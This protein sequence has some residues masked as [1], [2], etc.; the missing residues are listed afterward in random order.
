MKT[1]TGRAIE[2]LE[3][4]G[5]T[6]GIVERRLSKK[7]QKDLFGFADIVAINSSDWSGTLAVQVTDHTS[8]S[9]RLKK[10]LNEPRAIECL[11]CGWRIEVWGIRD[12]PDS[13]G[14][15]L[16]SRT[17]KLEDGEVRVIE[18]SLVLDV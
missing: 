17:L 9:K 14:K 5:W 2:Y 12:K 8:V 4:I 6:A 13:K 15:Y 16:K 3:A 10:T 18:G 7:V 11:K 1:H